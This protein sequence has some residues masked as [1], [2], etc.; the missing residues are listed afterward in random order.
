MIYSD[1]FMSISLPKTQP[2]IL[3]APACCRRLCNAF[4][5]GEETLRISQVFDGDEPG[6]QWVLA[7]WAMM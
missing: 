7:S 5:N 6:Y 2:T 1:M 3:V 4:D